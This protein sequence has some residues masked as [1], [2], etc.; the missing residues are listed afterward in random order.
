MYYEITIVQKGNRL[1]S[2]DAQSI[3]NKTQLK[4]I[5]NLFKEKFPL[6]EGYEIQVTEFQ[7]TG[8]RI[9]DIEHYLQV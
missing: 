4:K 8:K 6:Y 2:T 7:T 1:F 9:Q 3:Q 5:L